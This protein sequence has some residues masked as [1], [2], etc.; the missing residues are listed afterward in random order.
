MKDVGGCY[1]MKLND[2]LDFGIICGVVGF[3]A[4]AI[5]M[6]LIVGGIGGLK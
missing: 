5:W 2:K 3:I 6:W 4:G 1:L